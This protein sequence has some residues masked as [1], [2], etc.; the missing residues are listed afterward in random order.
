M[1]PQLWFIPFAVME[2]SLKAIFKLPYPDLKIPW[3]G[4]QGQ[5]VE[6]KLNLSYSLA[7]A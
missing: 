5:F 1:A 6:E 3:K 4:N 7:T 2:S